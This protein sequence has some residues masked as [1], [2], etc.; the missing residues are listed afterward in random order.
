MLAVSLAQA[1]SLSFSLY[2]IAHYIKGNVMFLYIFVFILWVASGKTKGSGPL[3]LMV[4]VIF[5]ICYAL[6]LICLFLCQIFVVLP[7]L[8]SLLTLRPSILLAINESFLIFFVAF[9]PLPCQLI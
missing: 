4:A 5:R 2:P 3:D 1:P 8:Q 6:V 7:Q 9:M